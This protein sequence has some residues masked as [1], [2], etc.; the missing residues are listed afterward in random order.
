MKNTKEKK[1]SFEQ[2][3]GWFLLS[4]AVAAIGMFGVMLFPGEYDNPFGIVLLFAIGLF[5]YSFFTKKTIYA[6]FFT[7]EED[8]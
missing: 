8:K 1:L 5:V 4:I 3:L 2:R 6:T 7:Y